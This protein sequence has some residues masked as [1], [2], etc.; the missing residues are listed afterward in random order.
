M[1]IMDLPKWNLK[2][3]DDG[4]P[5]LDFLYDPFDVLEK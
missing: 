3:I 4:K 1:K 2:M 5:T